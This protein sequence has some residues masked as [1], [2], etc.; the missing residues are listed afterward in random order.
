MWNTF[1]LSKV[2]DKA[3]HD[4]RIQKLNFYAVRDTERKL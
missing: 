2:F 4:I 1:R 3:D